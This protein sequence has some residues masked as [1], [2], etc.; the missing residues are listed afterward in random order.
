MK[1]TPADE[2]Y[3]EALRELPAQPHLT[4]T[5][6]LDAK[7]VIAVVGSRQ[8]LEDMR[9]FA[10]TLAGKLARAGATVVSGGAVGIDAA[11]HQGALDAGGATWVVCGTGKNHV[12]PPEHGPLFDTIARSDGSRVIWPFADEVEPSRPNFRHRNGVLV[13]L[14]EAVIVVQSRLQ[15]GSRNAAAWARSLKRP[16]W[17]VLG[18]PYG[19]Y[20]D[21]CAGSWADHK[22]GAR[23]LGNMDELFKELDLVPDDPQQ[24]RQK[25]ARRKKAPAQLGPVG[26]ELPLFAPRLSTDEKQV[27]SVLSLAPKHVDEIVDLAGLGVSSTVTALLTLS[28]KDVVVEGPD[29]FFRRK[30]AR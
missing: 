23:V 7:R 16:T 4:V 6:P 22:L 21:A 15:S 24:A 1:L 18:L 8:P 3:P 9:A 2:A 12:Y 5:G 19:P 10:H 29:G 11:A 27:I 20:L 26:P 28:M 30:K 25:R 17:V 13:A 14:A